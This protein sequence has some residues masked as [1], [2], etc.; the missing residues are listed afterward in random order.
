MEVKMSKSVFSTGVFL[1]AQQFPD[2]K[3]RWVAAGFEDSSFMFGTGEYVMPMCEADSEGG[4]LS[5]DCGE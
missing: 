3:W 4:L 5:L 2:G 1:N